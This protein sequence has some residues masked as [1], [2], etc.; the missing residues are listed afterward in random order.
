MPNNQ[1]DATTTIYK[2][3][4]RFGDEILQAGFTSVPNLVLNHYAALDITAAEMMFTI[5]VWQ[6][7]WTEKD[8]YP[9]LSAIAGK[10]AVSVR[11]VHNYVASLKK[12]G[13]LIVN[14]RYSPHLGQMTSEYDFS[15]L[16]RAVL[17]SQNNNNGNGPGEPG[18]GRKHTP[19]KHSSGGGV[20]DT[21]PGG[22]K[23]V[24]G[25]PVKGS[26]YEEYKIKS[27]PVEEYKT[28]STSNN[29]L[30]DEWKQQ[31]DD[32]PEEE[33]QPYKGENGLSSAR[34]GSQPTVI[35]EILNK[36]GEPLGQKK[37]GAVAGKNGPQRPIEGPESAYNPTGAVSGRP[38]SET[39][40]QPLSRA[41]F[42]DRG[43]TDRMVDEPW[44]QA[45]MEQWSEIDLNDEGHIRSNI[46]QLARLYRESGLSAGAFQAKMFEAHT[47]TLKRRSAVRKRLEDGSGKNLAPYFFACLKDLVGL[48][49]R[50]R[51]DRKE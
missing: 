13:Y 21:S 48:G 20:K 32:I 23:D 28:Y 24:S 16:L 14:Q 41:T 40:V 18:D 7:W 22:M 10:M 15:P 31:E 33:P 51:V 4:V 6:Y 50:V 39:S 5:H 34:T 35:G 19:M 49:R 11:Q 29:C 30:D 26:A 43:R 45:L 38:G 8:P 1:D 46:S 37:G 12:K 9:S 42:T 44:I 17:A 2:I 47:I 25:V 27:Y 3:A 36:R